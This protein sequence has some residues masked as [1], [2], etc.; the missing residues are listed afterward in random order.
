[1]S[2]KKIGNKR[3]EDFPPTT[4]YLDDL[5]E[6]VSILSETCKEVE[7]RYLRIATNDGA[8]LIELAKNFTDDALMMSIKSYNPY[9]S[10]D[11]QVIWY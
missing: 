8:E 1:M 11:H 4:I 2:L 9:I 5:V 10:I 7:I 3:I 6:V